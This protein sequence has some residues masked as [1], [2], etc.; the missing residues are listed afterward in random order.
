MP[1]FH[2]ITAWYGRAFSQKTGR[3][4]V[5]FR[6]EL[7]Y[8]PDEPFKINCLQ[9]WGCRL[10]KS[11]EWAIRCTHEASMHEENCFITL[12]YNDEFLPEWGDLCKE[13][14]Q[15]FMKRLRRHLSS[16]E[17]YRDYPDWSSR[18]IKY[19]MCGEYGERYQRPHYHAC[20][21]GFNF[22]DRYH[23]MGQGKFALYR[24]PMLEYL[25]RDVKSGKPLGCCAV[26]DV[27]FDSAAYVARYVMKKIN[28]VME[29]DY[30]QGHPKEFTLMSRK[31]PIGKEFYDRYKSDMYPHG[32]V[33]L[34]NGSHVKTPAYYDKMY[35]LTNPGL[36]SR[37]KSER[38][39]KRS[40]Q[41]TSEVAIRS[42][43]KVAL[44]F[45]KNKNRRFESEELI[46]R[47]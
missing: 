37:I 42:K 30:Y 17:F 15:K 9:C 5:V 16:D 41:D 14:F 26:G 35:D 34:P 6:K 21:F 18:H 29:E 3:R 23:W 36:Y 25:W 31:P 32:T 11:R 46:I 33:L 27:S 20:I 43:E 13:D 47:D 19:Y 8:R 40:K 4:S 45:Y 38:R 12:T 39:G 24:S 1:C 2:P 7:A 10:D 28:G 22:P 44:H